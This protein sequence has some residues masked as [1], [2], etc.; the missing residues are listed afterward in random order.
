MDV[1]TAAVRAGEEAAVDAGAGELARNAAIGELALA[2]GMRLQEFSSLLAY[3]IPPLPSQPVQVPIPFPVPASV[4]KGRKFRTTWI[5]YNALAAVRHYLD[6]DRPATVDGTGWR[7][8][9]RWVSRC[10]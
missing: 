9:T 4:A 3:E 7:P 8:S 10:W 5:S 1:G 6:L 2:T